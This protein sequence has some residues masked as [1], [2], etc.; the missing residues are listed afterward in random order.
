MAV[1]YQFNLMTFN[2]AK[3]LLMQGHCMVRF[4]S[5]TTLNNIHE[6]VYTIPKSIQSSGDKI[7]VWN[8]NLLK[9]EDIEVNTIISITPI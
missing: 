8:I 1:E 9:W 5:L 3:T 2:E 6:G 7:L 4:K